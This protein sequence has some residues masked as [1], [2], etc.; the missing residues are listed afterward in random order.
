MHPS[1]EEQPPQWDAT[2]RARMK[3]CAHVPEW[4]W[5]TQM[6]AICKGPALTQE[7]ASLLEIPERGEWPLTE[8]C[9]KPHTLPKD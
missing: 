7:K 4:V 2:E 5:K 3:M 6:S 1:G 9:S 8:T